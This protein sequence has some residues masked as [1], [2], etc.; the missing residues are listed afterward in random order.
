MRGK[1]GVGRAELRMA[2]VD[3][4]LP[5]SVEVGV[6]PAHI[7]IACGLELCQRLSQ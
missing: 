6:I 5:E 2:D 4:I 7:G 1:V 3:G